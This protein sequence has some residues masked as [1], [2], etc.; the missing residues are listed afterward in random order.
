MFSAPDLASRTTR[1]QSIA[2]LPANIVQGNTRLNQV[3]ET[4]GYNFQQQLYLQLAN[5]TKSSDGQVVTVITPEKT[6]SILSQNNLTIEQAYQKP[7]SELAK[8]FAVDAIVLVTLSDNGNFSD[9]PAPGLSGG[10]N[11]YNSR[12]RNNNLSDQ[13]NPRNL[14]MA[15][16]VY[17]AIDGKLLWRTGRKAGPDLSTNM[18]AVIQY[19]AGLIVRKFPYKT[20]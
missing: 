14:D 2:I 3:V 10:Q 20:R 7:P 4:Y 9:G 16:N 19:Y 18:D 15:A 5:T 12:G 17:D 6:K 8:L 13:L 1:H 11:V